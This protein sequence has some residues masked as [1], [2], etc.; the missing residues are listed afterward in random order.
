[1]DFAYHWSW[2]IS[3]CVASLTFSHTFGHTKL[4]LPI[5]QSKWTLPDRG[6]PPISSWT[7]LCVKNLS[8]QDST[9]K[10]GLSVGP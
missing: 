6:L 10:I 2:D 7:D 8:G 4:K 3:I 9:V 5:Q 1:M